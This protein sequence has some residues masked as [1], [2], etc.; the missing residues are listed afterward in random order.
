MGI[1]VGSGKEAGVSHHRDI[2]VVVKHY[3]MSL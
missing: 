3:R 1:L 2:S